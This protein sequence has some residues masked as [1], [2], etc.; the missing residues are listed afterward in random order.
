MS[1]RLAALC[2]LAAFGLAGATL[3]GQEKQQAP[4]PAAPEFKV[5]PDEAKRENPVK[6]TPSSIA[7]GKHIFS[8]Q[9][10]MCHGKDADGQGELAVEM[11][12]KLKDY[13][14]PAALKDV[15]DG[16]LSY[17]IMKGKGDM[18]GQEDRMKRDQCWNLINYIRSIAKKD[19]TKGKEE[20]PK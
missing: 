16:E 20:K 4:P 8:T 7:D 3:A 1:D 17:I 18:P 15:T 9:C 19:A 12:L 14:D 10:I 11:K 6:P 2:M 13:R 5:P